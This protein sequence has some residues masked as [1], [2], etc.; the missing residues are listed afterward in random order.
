M[1]TSLM[2][3]EFLYDI[4]PL[5]FAASSFVIAL[6]AAI[7]VLLH[8]RDSRAMVAW[9]GLI[10]LS[11]LIGATAYLM[12]GINRVKRRAS[13]LRQAM[14]R[15]QGQYDLAPHQVTPLEQFIPDTLQPLSRL[16]GQ[17][18]RQP[19]L[20]GN[21]IQP[22]INGDEA[23]PAMLQAIQGAQTSITLSSYIFNNDV[24]GRRFVEALQAAHQ[25]GVAVRI[26]IDGMGL[27]YSWPSIRGP[28][29]AAQLPHAIFLPPRMPTTLPFINLRNHRKILVVDGRY[30]FTGGMNI[31]LGNCLALKPTAPIHDL[32]FQ[33]EGPVVNELQ[34]VFAED[35]AFTCK[36]VLSGPRWFPA[37]ET[38]GSSL[39][40]VIADGPDEDYDA[41]RQLLLGAITAAQQQIHIIT[42]YFLPDASLED[43]LITAALR[44]VKIKI[45]LPQHNNIRMVD[46]ASRG[47]LSPLLMRGIDIALQPGHFSH[48][49]SFT[50][51]GQWLLLGSTNWDPRSLALNFECA[52]ECYDD[53]LASQMDDTFDQHWQ[54]SKLLTLKDLTEQSPLLKLRNA[55]ARLLTPYL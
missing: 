39:A 49:K 55:T 9:M 4:W 5:L 29:K 44:G 37:P 20:A 8:K 18:S 53:W 43:A 27:R 45:L 50:V 7:H 28:L 34:A 52:V 17:V 35:W 11:P 46:W 51:D 14:P 40:R 19:L 36:E 3:H 42:P 22:L 54:Q 25:R 1:A 10:W 48:A 16:A 32:H 15:V 26:L 41:L 31:S 38:P 6:S 33:L 47:L 23:Y 21:R 13:A 12:L 24:M 2:I 30:G